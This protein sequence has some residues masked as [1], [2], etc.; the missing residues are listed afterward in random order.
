MSF[1]VSIAIEIL[2]YRWNFR[3]NF[4]AEI[5][6]CRH[7]SGFEHTSI[8]PIL[9]CHCSLPECSRYLYLLTS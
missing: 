4:E 5:E 7:L 2:L 6:K 1:N 3:A 8:S 9:H